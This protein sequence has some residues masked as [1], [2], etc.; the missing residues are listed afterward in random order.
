[1]QESYCILEALA[2]HHL[3]QRMV[4]GPMMVMK[5]MMITGMS[6]QQLSLDNFIT[7]D[8]RSRTVAGDDIPRTSGPGSTNSEPARPTGVADLFDS[9]FCPTG[10]TA[11]PN[12]T[13][14]IPINNE[15]PQ[16]DP[17]PVAPAPHPAIAGLINQVRTSRVSVPGTS[18]AGI[19]QQLTANNVR[20]LQGAPANDAVPASEVES[21]VIVTGLKKLE[22]NDGTPVDDPSQLQDSLLGGVRSSQPRIDDNHTRPSVGDA[23]QL[24]T[25]DRARNPALTDR[26]LESPYHASS[27]GQKPTKQQLEKTSR[28]PTTSP[29]PKRAP[30]GESI[31]RYGAPS[32]SRTPTPSQQQSDQSRYSERPDE[33]SSQLQGLD[34]RRNMADEQDHPRYLPVR[35]SSQGA[36]SRESEPLSVQDAQ[37]VFALL[38]SRVERVVNG[39]SRQITEHITQVFSQVISSLIHEVATPISTVV[40]ELNDVVTTRLTIVDSSLN[41]T[42][43]FHDSLSS[44]LLLT[45]R[46]L[47]EL[48]AALTKVS[49]T[50]NA[51]LTTARFSKELLGLEKRL[52]SMPKTAAD[53]PQAP[54]GGGGDDFAKL[55][56]VV[57]DMSAKIAALKSKLESVR[58]PS[59]FLDWRGDLI[60]DLTSTIDQRASKTEQLMDQRVASSER[61]IL[62][63][64]EEFFNRPSKEGSA[65][66]DLPQQLESYSE[67][68]RTDSLAL[69]NKLDRLSSLNQAEGAR[70]REEMNQL[71]ETVRALHLRDSP[72]HLDHTSPETRPDDQPT[73]KAISLD[74]QKRLTTAIHKCVWPKFSGEGEYDHLA[75]IQWID[76]AQHDS[77]MLDEEIIVKFL[78]LFTDV[79]LTWYNTMR[80]T[81]KNK[82]WA[83]WKEEICKKFGHSSWKRKRQAA[84]E[85]DRFIP[86]DTPVAAWVTRQY[87]RLQS[88]DPLISQESI[89]FKLL[90]LMEDEVEYAAARA[91]P[92]PDTDLSSFIT[93]LEDIASKTRLGRRKLTS[94]PTHATQ[95][96]TPTGSKSEPLA[97]AKKLTCFTCRGVGHTSRQCPKKVNNVGEDETQDQGLDEELGSDIDNDEPVIGQST[98]GVVNISLVFRTIRLSAR[99][100]VMSN[101]SARYFILGNDYLRKFCISLLN[102]D[103][104]QRSQERR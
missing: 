38:F 68:Q 24:G 6:S 80:L 56:G 39:N 37:K 31:S 27:G 51:V 28:S 101:M 73:A 82:L 57:Q 60:N 87:N 70:L 50:T 10:N 75:F 95:S 71:S 29:P 9:L 45:D 20:V 103:K 32:T 59:P 99:F 52:R 49:E 83:F 25:L 40:H 102:G 8:R 15:N 81:H 14:A 30:T 64:L 66:S 74:L 22:P 63:K 97:P 46:K 69:S 44:S 76:T 93:I 53:V 1:M 96:L 26:G 67:S 55:I 54:S 91:M 2:N 35:G 90:G 92:T 21:I 5:R 36:E 47:N 65:P 72:P 43:S 19:Q 62:A 16:N 61:L 3:T 18:T 41:K 23:Q 89:N 88:F 77:N 85:A 94:K 100:V 11:V 4:M 13:P 33:R 104:R 48:N 98:L 17:D 78:D 58:L 86:G 42:N 7:S 34:L 84:F 79:A 12:A